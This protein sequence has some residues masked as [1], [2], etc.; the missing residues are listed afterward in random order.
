[1]NLTLIRSPRSRPGTLTQATL[2]SMRSVLEGW[3]RLSQPTPDATTRRV[4]SQ[5]I[6]SIDHGTW[7]QDVA[8]LPPM[9]L[10][11]VRSA[12]MLAHLTDEQ[13]LSR[14]LLINRACLYIDP[15]LETCREVVQLNTTLESVSTFDDESDA[16]LI[17]IA[18]L[19]FQWERLEA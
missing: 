3:L 8:L 19:Q 11:A 18:L 4:L 6:I 15:S 9:V 10:S 7:L 1:M 2:D 5:A 16:Q 17:A 12:A 13:L 14:W